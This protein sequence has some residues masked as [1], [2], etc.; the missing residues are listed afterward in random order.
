MAEDKP[1]SKQKSL[2]YAYLCWMF[3]GLFGLHHL[4]L[5]RDDHAFLTM[6]TFGGYFS[7]GLIRDLWRLPEYVKDANNDSKYVVELRR[8]MKQHPSPPSGSARLSALMIVGSFFGT[9]IQYAIPQEIFSETTIL[10]LNYI[11]VPFG[12]AIGVWLVGNVG[13][14]QGCLWKPLVASYLSIPASI[15]TKLPIETFTTLFSLLAFNKFSKNWRRIPKKQRSL[16]YRATRLLFAISI[17]FALMSSWLY[18][19]C[20]IED[21]DTQEPIKCREAI[22]NFLSSSALQNLSE[23]IWVIVE[24]VRH[25]GFM[26]IWK[27]IRQEFDISGRSQA[28]ATLGLD[29]SATHQQIVTTYKDLMLKYH[30]DK[31][32]DEAKKTVKQEQFIKV[33]EAYNK[34][35]TR[36]QR[37]SLQASRIEL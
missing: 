25:N 36:Q 30:P 4:Y 5:G 37:A 20:T 6:A 10:I 23:A 35:V 17:Y 34:L 24:Q 16:F 29:E 1:N 15:I 27:Q 21:A 2:F 18:F 14:H 32:H 28:L 3:G 31:E 13:R 19:E 22:S 7:I 33:K 26:N 11:F 12:S 8:Q 9:L